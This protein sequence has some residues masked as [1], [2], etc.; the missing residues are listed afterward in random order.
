L[1]VRPLLKS[2]APTEARVGLE[3]VLLTYLLLTYF[4]QHDVV[5]PNLSAKAYGA[6]ADRRGY[7]VMSLIMSLSRITTWYIACSYPRKKHVC[8]ES[9]IS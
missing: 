4:S 1:A 5:N 6:F 2:R 9:T 3:H 8:S 7:L